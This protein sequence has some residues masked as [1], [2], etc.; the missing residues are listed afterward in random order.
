MLGASRPIEVPATSHM[1]RRCSS[2]SLRKASIVQV[3]V[4]AA[5][6][7]RMSAIQADA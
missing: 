5:T 2:V 6:L 1:R 7:R 4:G 3:F